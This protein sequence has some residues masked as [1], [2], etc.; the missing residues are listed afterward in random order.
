MR[1]IEL[2]DYQSWMFEVGTKRIA[3]DPWLRD[4]IEFP[5]GAWMLERRRL[6]QQ[7]HRSAGEEITV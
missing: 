7:V 2:D 3:L 6:T 4:V 5:A 1:I